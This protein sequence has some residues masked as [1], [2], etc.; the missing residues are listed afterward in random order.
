MAKYEGL[1]NGNI[2]KGD[3]EFKR[4][5]RKILTDGRKDINPRPHYSDGVP[6]HTISYNHEMSTYDLNAG[7]LPLMT[8][9]PIAVKSAIGE[10]LWIYQDASNDLNLFRDKYNAKWWDEWEVGD[11]RTIGEVYG[12]TVKNYDL[13]HRLLEGLEK[14]PDGRRH[15]MSLWQETDFT[16]PHG[17]KPCCF[18]TMWNVRHEIDGKDYL[19]MCMIQRS[20]DYVTAGS[21]INQLQ[22]VVLQY[23]VARHIKMLPGKFTWFVDNIQIYDRHISAAKE[24]LERNPIS[25][26][27]SIW[28]NPDVDNFYD[29]TMNDIKIL[30]YPIE[31]IKK[32]NPN[33][34]LDLGI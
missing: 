22:Y 16:K 33:F 14:D 8:L 13:M 15:I 3:L 28:L 21:S 34:K 31:E 25:C 9:R 6:A 18:L 1:I 29:F 19:D 10:I 27:P 20:C 4:I 32:I 26:K 5:I 30:N 24:M 23:L 2:L 11:T 12:K 7:E 17:L